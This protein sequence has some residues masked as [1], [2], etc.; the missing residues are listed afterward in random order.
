MYLIPFDFTKYQIHF[1]C[2]AIPIIGG[3]EI[4]TTISTTTDTTSTLTTD[5]TSTTETTT[6]PPCPTGYVRTPSGSCVNLLI[7]FNNCGSIGYVCASTYTSCSNGAC[8]GAPAVQLTGAVA[9]P[10]WGGAYSV[11]DAYLLL[12]LPFSI[13]LYG[14]S[15]STASVQSNGASL[16]IVSYSYFQVS[17]GGAS[18]TIGVQSSTS[19]PSITY[20]VDSVT[21]PYGASTTSI[22]TLTLTFDTNAGTYTSSG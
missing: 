14:Y 22:P 17:D 1:S 21:L 9:V 5:T 3:G 16:D 6:T 19:G 15:T 7:D 8:S 11:D 20:S 12:S 4:T 18:A 13:S 2:N 10:G